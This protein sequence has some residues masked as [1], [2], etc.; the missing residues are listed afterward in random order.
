MMNTDQFFEI[1]QFAWSQA[2]TFANSA[3]A[4]AFLSALAGAGLGVWGAQLVAER[5]TRTRE[6]LEGLRQAN[7]V[8]V[9]STIIVNQALSLKRQHVSPLS[10][11]YFKDREV[12]L[13]YHKKVLNGESPAPIV[14]QAEMVKVS[15]VAMPLDALKNLVYSAQLMPGRALALV[16]MIEQYSNELTHTV[17]LRTELIDSLRGTSLPHE[18]FFQDY[19]GIER[20]DGNTNSMYYDSM[21]AITQYTDDVAFFASELAEEMQAYAK[22]VREKLVKFRKDAPKASTI[23]FAG[24]RES[25]LLP[26]KDNYASWLAGFKEQV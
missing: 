12:A 26:P 6:L 17:G 16:A 15:P 14:F 22:A 25:G 7:A 9:L 2:S 13:A 19:Y 18:L 21:V 3:F 5:G 1:L 23:D 10:E 20:R 4:S 24:A 11:R 8:M